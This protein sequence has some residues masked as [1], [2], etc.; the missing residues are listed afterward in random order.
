MISNLIAALKGS[1]KQVP[2]VNL[3]DSGKVEQWFWKT[4]GG[5]E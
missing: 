4:T 1:N 5:R 3:G 2:Q